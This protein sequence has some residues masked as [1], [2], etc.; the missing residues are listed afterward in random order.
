MSTMR[1]GDVWLQMKRR[2]KKK[3]YEILQ[4]LLFLKSWRGSLGFA[5]H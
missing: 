2:K 5:P 3:I 4:R 1:I